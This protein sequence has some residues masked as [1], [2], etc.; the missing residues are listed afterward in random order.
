MI[1]HAYRARAIPK[2]LIAYRMHLCWLVKELLAPNAPTINNEKEIDRY[3]ERLKEKLLDGEVWNETLNNTCQLFK[4]AQQ[5]WIEE[6]GLSYKYGM[7]DSTEFFNYLREYIRTRE[8][9]DIIEEKPLQYRGKVVKTGTDRHGN[10]YGF[11]SRLPDNIFFH[12]K[13]NLDLNFTNLYAQ[14]VLYSITKD[15]FGNDKAI[16]VVPV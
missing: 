7:K 2:E 9:V 12:E 5:K 4:N 10:Y 11:I 3:C 15:R 1:D 14:E 6:K 16:D 13:D 8:K